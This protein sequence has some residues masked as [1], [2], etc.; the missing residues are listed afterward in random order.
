MFFK[1]QASGYAT[2]REARGGK[3]E[4]AL[5]GGSGG[6]EERHEE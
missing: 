4:R 1:G 3:K 5:E 6:G 2:G